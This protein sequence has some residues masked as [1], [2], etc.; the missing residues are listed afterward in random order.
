MPRPCKCR[1]INADPKFLCFKPRGI[2][3]D[4]LEIVELGLDEMEAVHLIDFDD[5]YQTDAAQQMGISQATIGRLLERA[6]KKIADALINGKALFIKGGKTMY[7]ERTFLCDQCNK[8]FKEPCGTSRSDACPHCGSKQFH[9]SDP[10]HGFATR[11][12]DCHAFRGGA[13]LTDNEAP[14]EHEEGK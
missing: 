3:L 10:S 7:R 5:L 2:P 8:E 9:R 12:G 6:H 11:R 13:I 14:I 1:F 4:E